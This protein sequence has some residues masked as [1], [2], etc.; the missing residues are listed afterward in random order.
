MSQD[1]LEQKINEI[2]LKGGSIKFYNI[3][4]TKYKIVIGLGFPKIC[5]VRRISSFTKGD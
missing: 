3:P 5:K 4:F 2:W 1:K